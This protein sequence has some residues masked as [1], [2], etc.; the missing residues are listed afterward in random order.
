MERT[1]GYYN[2]FMVKIWC[3][4]GRMRGYIQHIGSQEHAYF[5][6]MEDMAQFITSHLHPPAGNPIPTNVMPAILPVEDFKELD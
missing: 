4:R 6:N 1:G 3:D 5:L 2:S